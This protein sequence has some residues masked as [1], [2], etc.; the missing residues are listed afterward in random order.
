MADQVTRAN[1]TALV[2]RIGGI[3]WDA[4]YEWQQ[5]HPDEMNA[6]RAGLQRVAG[7]RCLPLPSNQNDMCWVNNWHPN[8]DCTCVKD[9]TET[10]MNTRNTM[11]RPTIS[12]L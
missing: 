10:E 5:L 12:P 9:Q 3:N 8:R 2:W 11:A 4:Y 1:T 6:L 7:F